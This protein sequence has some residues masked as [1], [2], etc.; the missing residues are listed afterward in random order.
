MSVKTFKRFMLLAISLGTLSLTAHAQ[1][2]TGAGASF[3]YPVYA[4]WSSLYEKETGNKVNY[5]SIGSGGGQQQIIAKTIDFGASDDPMKAELLEQHQLLQFPAIIGGTVPVVNIPN[6]QPG[7]LKLSGDVLAKIFLGEIKTWNDPAVAAL[8]P[9]LNLPSNPIIVVHRSDGS[10]T[11]FGWTNYLSKVSAAWKAKVGEGKSV[12]WPTG[13]GGKGN[14]GVSA[15]VKQLK[16]SIGYVEYAYAKQ[17]NL[18]WASLQNKAGEFVQPS[19]ESFM[20]AAAN[21]KWDEKP[22]MGVVLTDEDGK[23]SW[24]VTAASFILLHKVAD[25]AEAT[26]GVFQFFDWAFSK[27]QDAASELDYVPLPQEVVNQIKAQWTSEVKDKNG[28]AIQ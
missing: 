16:F 12:K 9:D 25:N 7:Q 23:A 19:K 26:K 5:Q 4:K 27:G 17:N 21:A 13:Q 1:T 6:V 2:I 11:T 8:N 22:G 10:G 14:E 15:Y 20:S 28:K 24:P 18:A 3:P